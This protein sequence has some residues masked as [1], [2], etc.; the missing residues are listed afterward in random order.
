MVLVIAHTNNTHRDEKSKNLFQSLSGDEGPGAIRQSVI[1]PFARRGTDE[2]IPIGV[3]HQTI[4]DI[5]RKK[6]KVKKIW[7]TLWRKALR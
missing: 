1:G 4:D 6:N 2:G 7:F 3:L 5:I